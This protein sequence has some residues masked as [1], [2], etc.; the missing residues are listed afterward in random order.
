MVPEIQSET[1]RN[2]CH[3]GPFCPFNPLATQKIKILKLKKKNKKKNWGYYRFTHLHYKG[4]SNNVWF[5]RYRVRQ[6]E[7]F[8]ILDHFL[9][10]HPPKDLENQNFEKVKK[11]PEDLPF[12][13]CIP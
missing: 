10:F 1:E 6:A 9:P 4:Q 13:K 2:V 8:V 3:F 7:C 5:L 12:Y 11:T